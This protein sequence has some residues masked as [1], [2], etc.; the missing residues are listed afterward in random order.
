VVQKRTMDVLNGLVSALDL[1]DTE[2]QNHSRR[3]SLYAALVAERLG[4]RGTELLDIERG[5]LLHDIGKIGVRDSI[6]LKP[7]KL[8]PEEWVEMRRH[9]EL[10]YRLLEGIEF[11]TNA[12]QVVLHHQE[13]YDGSGYPAGLRG[14]QICLGARIFAVVDAL[15]A[16]TCDRRYRRSISFH[17]SRREIHRCANS[18]FD[19]RVVETF[20][21]ISEEEFWEIRNRFND[22]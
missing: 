13:H 20:L 17:D 12:R 10:G 3:V 18:Q 15:D 14:E 2:T 7:D 9:P 16:M 22:A 4:V 8:T 11:L 21:T 6:L 19:P 1:R 5:A